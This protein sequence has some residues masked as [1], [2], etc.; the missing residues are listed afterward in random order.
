MISNLNKNEFP[1]GGELGLTVADFLKP[2][3]NTGSHLPGK[4][5][6]LYLDNGRSAIYLALLSIINRGGKREAWLPCYCCPSIIAPFRQLGFRLKF[7]SLGRSL[8]IPAS[9]P[10]KMQGETFLFIHYFGKV[11][12]VLLDYLQQMKKEQEFFVIEDCVQAL[13]NPEVGSYDYA[14]YSCRKFLPQPDGALLASDFSLDRSQIEPADEA[15]ISRK[16]IAKLIRP[17]DDE[18]CL[19]LS[20]QAEEF[21]DGSIRPRT[22]SFLSRYLLARTNAAEIAEKRRANFFYLRDL[23]NKPEEGIPLFLLFDSLDEQEVPLGLPV[24]T[25]PGCRDALRN[26]LK[27]YSIYCPVHW[28]MDGAGP[29]G[30]KDEWYLSRNILTLPLDQRYDFTDLNFLCSKITEFFKLRGEMPLHG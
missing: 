11:N 5:N 28:P 26:F 18:K 17:F 12:R 1:I 10:D 13:L 29:G 21:I 3:A 27:S 24:L 23:L 7:Y 15:F 16:M 20:T 8:T 30:W 25:N 6:H 22:M 2:V 9:L 14:V 4:K 19:D